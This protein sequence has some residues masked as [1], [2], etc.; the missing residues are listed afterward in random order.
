MW[1][2]NGSRF[3]GLLE[4]VS[5]EA[6]CRRP[7]NGWSIKDVLAHL[8]CWHRLSLGWY[9]DGLRN[10]PELPA[11]GYNWGQTQQLNQNFFEEY[12]DMELASVTRRLKLSHGRVMKLVDQ[13]SN[14]Q[15]MQPGHFAWTKKLGLISYVSANTSSHYRWAKKKIKKLSTTT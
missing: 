1:N 13:L 8:Y 7:K 15:L 14:D 4:G 3:W 9:K 11:P 12:R 2:S 5:V 6:V 10:T